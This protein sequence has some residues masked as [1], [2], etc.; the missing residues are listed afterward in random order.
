MFSIFLGI[1]LNEIYL[2]NTTVLKNVS[3]VIL[4]IKYCENRVPVNSQKKWVEDNIEQGISSFVLPNSCH[5]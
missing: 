3:Q 5:I 1:R 2:S 4:V